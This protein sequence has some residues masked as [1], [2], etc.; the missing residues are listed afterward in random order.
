MVNFLQGNQTS[1]SETYLAK[2]GDETGVP[3]GSPS[4]H[5]FGSMFFRG[6]GEPAYYGKYTPWQLRPDTITAHAGYVDPVTGL[7]QLTDSAILVQHDLWVAENEIGLNLA[8][9]IGTLPGATT[10]VGDALFLKLDKAGGTIAGTLEVNTH[11][12]ADNAVVRNIDLSI[13]GGLP[14]FTSA[15]NGQE[16]KIVADTP[17]WSIPDADIQLATLG[18]GLSSGFG[19]ETPTA[20]LFNAANDAS[21]LTVDTYGVIT[22]NNDGLYLIWGAGYKGGMSSNS[23][24]TITNIS[25]GV[26]SISITL[27]SIL[28]YPNKPFSATAG[29]IL[30]ITSG[31]FYTPSDS[32]IAFIK[33][34]A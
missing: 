13:A 5:I 21:W 16:L 2:A 10:N 6:A 20:V 7:D 31:D 14:A 1:L 19:T 8:S 24:G 9:A 29:Q 11:S 28:K 32:A 12:S 4:T 27:D 15:N 25:V 23:D 17:T 33:K 3:A 18:I 22:I 30:V 26:T 34:L